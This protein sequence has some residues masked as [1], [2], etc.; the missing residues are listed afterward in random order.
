MTWPPPSPTSWPSCSGWFLLEASKYNVFPLDDR[1]VERFNPDMAGRPQLI[2]GNRQL[3]FAGMGRLTENSVVNLKNKSHAVTAQLVVADGG[4]Q[5]VL[6][7]QAAPSAAGACTPPAAGRPTA[8]TCSGCNASRSPATGRSRP[9]SIRCGWSSPTTAAGWPRAAPSPCSSTVRR[10][11]RAAFRDPADAVSLDETTD[12]GSDSATPVSDDY[13]PKDSAFTGRVRWIE[14][15]L[16]EDA[17]DLD[18][19][20]TAEERLRIAMA[21]Q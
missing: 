19:L 12:V 4:A 17:E 20:I 8:T 3:L 16:G 18:H 2:K 7:A 9:A 10:S 14:I 1:R 13:G 6:I 5:G 21:R 15:D 11:A